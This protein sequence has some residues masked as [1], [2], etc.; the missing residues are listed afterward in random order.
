MA[1]REQESKRLWSFPAGVLGPDDSVKGF[2]VEATDGHAG[3]VSWAS[4][5]TGESYLV[6]SHTHHLHE[7]HRVVPAGTVGR[8]SLDDHSV[9]LRLSREEIAELPEHHDPPA[10]IE[11]WMVEAIDRATARR[12]FGGD[13]W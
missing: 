7:T 10:P 12:A 8:I 6:V 11:S 1:E 5:A 9:W 4:Y 13:I 3:K 2:S